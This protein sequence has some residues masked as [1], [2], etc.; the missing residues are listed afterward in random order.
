MVTGRTE[1][2]VRVLVPVALHRRVHVRAAGEGLTIK[3]AVLAALEA[4]VAPAKR[5]G[6]AI[7]LD[8]VRLEG[9]RHVLDLFDEGP[10]LKIPREQVRVNVQAYIMSLSAAASPSTSDTMYT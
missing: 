3:A 8:Q 6:P 10:R 4:W 7:D 9:A 1:V 2:I 5:Q